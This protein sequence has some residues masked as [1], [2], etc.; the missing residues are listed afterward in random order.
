MNANDEI[1][2]LILLGPDKYSAECFNE[3]NY[4][5]DEG[6]FM[7]LID[8]E[9][10]VKVPSLSISNNQITSEPNMAVTINK[11][12]SSYLTAA[13]FDDELSSVRLVKAPMSTRPL[14]VLADVI[15][16]NS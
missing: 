9:Y 1:S 7:V 16:L 10:Y 11:M 14:T 15:A 4:D 8:A 2:S 13:T 5:D 6:K 12:P 3:T